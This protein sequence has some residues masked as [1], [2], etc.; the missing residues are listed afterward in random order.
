MGAVEHLKT[1]CCLGLPPES[2]MI[3]VTPLLHEIIPH[4]WTRMVLLEPN[5]AM[6]R[7]YV[8]YPGAADH[9][10]KNVSRFMDDPTSPWPMW[11]SYVKLFGIG[12]TLHMQGR[13]WLDTGWYREVEAHIDACWLLDGMVGD[14]GRPL[15]FV[16]L[17]RPRGARPFRV[18][19]VQRLDRVRP[20]LA[21]AFRE[22]RLGGAQGDQSLAGMAGVQVASGQMV[23]TPAARI[24]FQT[25]DLEFLLRAVLEGELGDYTRRVPQR[26]WLPAPV[27]KLLQ[28]II[29]AANGTTN[30]PPRTQVSTPYGVVT[31]EAKWLVPAGAI[32]EDVAKD[33]KGCLIAVTIELREHAV[34][35]AARVLRESGA[36]PAQMKVGIQLA[37]GK[38]KPAIANELSLKPTTIADLTRKLY[39]T[40][41]VHNSAELSTKIWLGETREEVHSRGLS[42]P[43]MPLAS[44]AKI[45]RSTSVFRS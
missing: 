18:D 15:A 43:P 36:T 7:G 9:L 5:G 20:W 11:T 19:D 26:D 12:W 40:L 10:A 41:D 29:G 23:L 4:G 45:A 44:G 38:T 6:S 16:V 32:P 28:Q 8:E 33:P 13:G 24:V 34:A 2:A 37:L 30:T 3:A 31:L 27:L 25:R 22:H 14:G 39:Q 21:H 42:G 35:H 1:L 17:S